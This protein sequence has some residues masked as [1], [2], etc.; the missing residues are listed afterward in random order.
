MM[1][2]VKRFFLSRST[3]LTIIL[4]ALGAVTLGALVPQEFITD[5][6]ELEKWRSLH[7]TLSTLSDLLGL[8]HVYTTPGFAVILLLVCISLTISTGEQGKSAWAKTFKGTPG[9]EPVGYFPITQEHAICVL[10]ALGYRQMS[11]ATLRFI[12]NPWGYWGAFSLHLGLLVCIAASLLIALTQQRGSVDLVRGETQL[13]GAPWTGEERGLLA[14]SLVL[15]EP[16]RLDGLRLDYSNGSVKGVEATLFFG[17]DRSAGI[18]AKTAINT[19]LSHEGLT[20][21]QGNEYGQ[22]FLIEIRTQTGELSRAAYSI[23]FPARIDEAGYNEFRVP[24]EPRLMQA[25]YSPF[26]S[27]KPLDPAEMPLT[28]RLMDNDRESARL[29][30]RQGE[31]GMLGGDRVAL[32]DV[33]DWG[34]LIF[35]RLYGIEGVFAG[36]FLIVIGAALTYC[37]PPREAVIVAK[38]EEVFLSWRS[39]RFAE[40]YREELENIRAGMGQER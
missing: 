30:L 7:P 32:L 31:S 9:G 29:T 16:V 22:A 5:R 4:L 26:A 13:A 37:M 8:W 1:T 33:R 34:R 2:R 20:I 35:V 18:M 38:G 14:G 23:R 12:K 40:L 28:L 10:R 25:K 15:P 6:I 19:P 11:Q 36:F 17:T 3:V 39:Q 27:G 24:G 21:Y